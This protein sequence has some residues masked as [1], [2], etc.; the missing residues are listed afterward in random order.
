MKVHRGGVSSR[1]E[2]GYP[3]LD[4]H[5]AT[6][7][8]FMDE[9]LAESPESSPEST[10]PEKTP[11]PPAAAAA[12]VRSSPQPQ[13]CVLVHCI[14]GVN[15]SGV[16]A[17]AYVMQS[18]RWPLLRAL[19]HCLEA[20]GPILWNETFRKQLFEFAKRE[21]LLV[22]DGDD[23]GAGIEEWRRS[24]TTKKKKRGSSNAPPPG[25]P[26]PPSQ[27]EHDQSGDGDGDTAAGGSAAAPPPHRRKY[28]ATPFL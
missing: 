9:A 22:V 6:F 4:L 1:D 23:G 13:P 10:S 17:A 27:Q 18:R 14:A 24:P 5:Y 28:P 26:P 8:Q 11:P 20:R 15:R 12:A 16:L 25:P 21:G 7:K 3:M 19:R 2:A